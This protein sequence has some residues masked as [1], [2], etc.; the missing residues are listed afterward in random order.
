MDKEKNLVGKATHEEIC[1]SALRDY[2]RIS[3][4]VCE[5]NSTIEKAIKFYRQ[6]GDKNFKINKGIK[7]L[8]R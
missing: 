8:A 1:D 5:W 6:F 2:L 4:D 7:S 3:S